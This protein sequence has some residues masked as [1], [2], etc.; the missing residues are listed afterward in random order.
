MA[1]VLLTKRIEFSASHR[2]YNEAWDAVRNRQVFGACSHA[3]GHGHNYLLEVTVEGDIAEET[4]M[5]VNLYDLKQVLKLVLQEFDHK[6]LNLDTNY[7]T[8]KIPT[9]ENIAGVL[10]S[11]L[12]TH[13]EIGQL[14]KIRLFEEDDL[15]ADVTAACFSEG[16][17][18]TRASLTRR[19][20]FSAAHRLGDHQGP[21]ITG[22]V[23]GKCRSPHLH[24]HNYTLQ[25][26][27]GGKIN[28]DTGMVTDL[29]ALD[30]TV[31]DRVLQRFDYRN[32]NEDPDLSRSGTTGVHVTR[33]V[34][35]ALVTSM[36]GG[37]LER[38][39]LAETAD[40]SYEYQ[41]ETTSVGEQVIVNQGR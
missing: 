4:G 2:Y 5:V 34:W 27:V 28:P 22:G 23:W 14:K 29:S 36:P 39:G 16:E 38:I 7:F 9:T 15:Y 25:V 1:K 33:F 24:G 8:T 30:R 10:W 12:A 17:V 13:A 11:V 18:L 35:D 32:L 19:Y 3:S 41:E 20:H 26:T 40:I 37:Q 21:N 31:H 6:H